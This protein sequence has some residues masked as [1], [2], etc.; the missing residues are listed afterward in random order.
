MAHGRVQVLAR[1]NRAA[2]LA[3]VAR[4][5]R[6]ANAP[7]LKVNAVA[8]PEQITDGP[9]AAQWEV[10]ACLT[11]GVSG[12]NGLKNAQNGIDRERSTVV[13]CT[14]CPPST[15]RRLKLGLGD[16]ARSSGTSEV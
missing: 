1:V 5:V 10:F 4:R 3:Q 2:R 9:L 11:V 13:Y 8:V 16:T 14:R 7:W 6:V 12:C 15:K